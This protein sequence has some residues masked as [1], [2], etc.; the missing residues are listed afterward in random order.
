LD[1]Q[2]LTVA[3][4]IDPIELETNSEQNQAA[5]QYLS[6][7]ADH[8]NEVDSLHGK[9]IN[10]ELGRLEDRIEKGLRAFWE[11]GNSLDQIRDKQLYQQS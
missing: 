11:I 9:A 1:T 2:N 8:L 4:D 6:N 7:R 5:N 10:V 3:E